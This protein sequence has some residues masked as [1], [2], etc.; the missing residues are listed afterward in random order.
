M[1]SK[2]LIKQTSQQ[3]LPALKDLFDKLPKED[4]L[5]GIGILVILGVGYKIIEAVKDIVLSKN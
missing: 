4:A 5:K 1:I 2:D 3:G